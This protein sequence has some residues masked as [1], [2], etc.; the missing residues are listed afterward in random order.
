MKL[1]FGNSFNNKKKSAARP[2][3]HSQRSGLSLI[4]PVALFLII[5]LPG[6]SNPQPETPAKDSGVRT[7]SPVLN[8]GDQFLTGCKSNFQSGDN[9]A[10]TRMGSDFIFFAFLMRCMN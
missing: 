5:L 6:Y 1:S 2:S 7:E 10:G 8:S 3:C 4:F 9:P